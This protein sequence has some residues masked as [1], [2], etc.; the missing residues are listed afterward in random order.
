MSVFVSYYI[1]SHVFIF[2]EMCHKSILFIT[3]EARIIYVHISNSIIIRNS[4]WY[5]VNHAYVVIFCHT[6]DYN[7]WSTNVQMLEYI[8]HSTTWR[9]KKRDYASTR[10]FLRYYRS[11]KD[12]KSPNNNNKQTSKINFPERKLNNE[13]VGLILINK[14]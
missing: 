12:R 10:I 8:Q 6:R 1:F 2:I 7:T 5:S 14:N 4:V 13:F 11:L 9:R 3:R